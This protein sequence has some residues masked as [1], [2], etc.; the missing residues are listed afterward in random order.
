MITLR[1]IFRYFLLKAEEFQTEAVSKL[2]F[3]YKIIPDLK[4]LSN[5]SKIT[6]PKNKI[7]IPNYKMAGFNLPNTMDL[8]LFG[9]LIS[10]LPLNPLPLL[11]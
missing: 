5:K 1:F 11:N 10:Q 6:L 4:L 7:T 3:S 2:I 8:N 9:T